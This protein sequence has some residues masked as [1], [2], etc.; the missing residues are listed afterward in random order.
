MNRAVVSRATISTTNI[1]GFLAICRGSSFTKAEPNA[2]QTI[3]GSSMAEAGMRWR[4]LCLSS[5]ML[6][7]SHSEQGAV[8]HRQMLDDRAER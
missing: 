8:D 1:T 5:K 7:E 2:G 4:G 6:R 3:F